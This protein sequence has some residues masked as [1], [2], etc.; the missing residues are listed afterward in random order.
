[1]SKKRS[2][3]TKNQTIQAGDTPL[4]SKTDRGNKIITSIVNTSIILMSTVMGAFTQVIVNA[5]S[6]MVSGMAEVI[7]GKEGEEK[8]NQEFKQKLPEVDEKMKALIS[9]IRK[10]FYTQMEQKRKEM[11]P[12]L[13]NP[14]F[15]VGPR[16]I[17]KYDFKLPKLTEELDDNVL[18]QYSLLLVTEDPRFAEMFKELTK[19]LNSLPQLPEQ[20]NKK[21]EINPL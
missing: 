12:L 4:Q 7:G 14:V 8:V 6:T 20:T 10:D 2:L 3:K 21:P 15:E 17:E 19:W 18:A 13:S 5:T 16:I 11:E 9:D 1:M